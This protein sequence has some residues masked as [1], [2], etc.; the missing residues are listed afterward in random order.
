MK[1]KVS[2]FIVMLLLLT[3]STE[4]IAQKKHALIIALSEY[5]QNTGWPS[6]SSFRDAALLSSALMN[7]G[8]ETDN[9]EIISDRVNGTKQGILRGFKTLTSKVK[10]G[11]IVVIHFSGHGQQ[12]IDKN[13]DENDGLDE[14]IVPV[15]AYS[16]FIPNIYEGQNHITDDELGNIL[17]KLRKKL[18]SQGDLLV[19]LDSCHSGTATRGK[20][21]FRGSENPLV[22]DDYKVHRGVDPENTFSIYKTDSNL[23]SMV[24]FSATV[25]NQLNWEAKDETGK[26][27]G[28]LSLAFSKALLQ[29]NQNTTYRGLFDRIRVIMGTYSIPLTPQIEGNMDRQI[30]GGKLV[31]HSPYF[32]ILELD[33]E[34]VKIDAGE[35][36]GVAVGSEVSFYDPDTRKIK[37]IKPIAKGIVQKVD[38]ISSEVKLDRTVKNR[39]ILPSWGYVTKRSFGKMNVS[40]GIDFYNDKLKTELIKGIRD[41][42]F[43]TVVEN[44]SNLQLQ[45]NDSLVENTQFELLDSSGLS[46][47]RIHS[48]N[49]IQKDV[50]DILKNIIRYAQVSFLRSVKNFDPNL[51]VELE[52]IPV[53]VRRSRSKLFI[54]ERLSIKSKIGTD[55][56]IR[57]RKG[58]YFIF[59]IINKGTKEVYITLLDIQPNNE[60]AVLVPRPDESASEYLV[61]PGDTLKLDHLIWKMDEPYG[62]DVFK[63]ISTDTELNLSVILDS[64]G[65]EINTKSGKINPFE[66]L[67]ANT[68]KQLPKYRA[69]NLPSIPPSAVNITNTIITIIPKTSY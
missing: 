2:Y 52:I 54:R 8:F 20:G 56:I 66:E 23:A 60:V 44:N 10:K 19:T 47:I 45:Q 43:I 36:H 12:V 26:N 49:D 3:I 61:Q 6:L 11:D 17:E 18:G 9:V 41:Y 13:G 16:I 15:D 63:L 31:D 67:F 51:Q 7:Q 69:K 5:N 32:K 21:K 22:P 29:S 50:D 46:L 35:L 33:G 34:I 4:V 25:P 38:H 1:I 24:V 68:F 58:D 53:K 39:K 48:S 27:I 40:I 42:P 14:A 62:N 55:G 28:S 59:N 57:F 64:D 30:F 65:S 37:K